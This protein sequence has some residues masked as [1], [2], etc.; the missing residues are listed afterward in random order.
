MLYPD[1]SVFHGKKCNLNVKIYA[2]KT[3]QEFFE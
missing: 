2:K 3:W 1:F